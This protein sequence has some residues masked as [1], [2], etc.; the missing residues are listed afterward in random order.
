MFE[1]LID[2]WEP[3]RA[4]NYRNALEKAKF[5]A[6]KERVPVVVSD[7]AGAFEREIVYPS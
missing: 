7:I 6:N 2:G 1:L 5:I 4:S 3:I